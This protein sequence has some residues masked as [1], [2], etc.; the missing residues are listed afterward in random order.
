MSNNEYR[1]AEFH[2]EFKLSHIGFQGKSR[3]GF[4]IISICFGRNNYLTSE[5]P[6][7]RYRETNNSK[8]VNWKHVQTSE[9]EDAF[10]VWRMMYESPLQNVPYF[11]LGH[12]FT[13]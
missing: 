4:R 5:Q 9:S 13:W 1:T 2:I 6:L 3:A 8:K 10:S 7:S 12:S 11:S